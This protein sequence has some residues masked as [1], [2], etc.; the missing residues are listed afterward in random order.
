[1]K[2][3]DCNY[4]CPEL[5]GCGLGFKLMQAFARRYRDETEVFD[6]LD[7]VAVSIAS[8]VVPIV[9]ENRVLA[10]YGLRK[11]N[12]NPLPGLKALKEVA[13]IK[14][15]LDISGVVFT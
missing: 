2:R 5:S 12:E 9:D 3:A 4:P 13:G 1:P 10:F 14:N 6:F 7:L 8:D 15:E 11:L